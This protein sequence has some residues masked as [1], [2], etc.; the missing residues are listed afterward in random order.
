MCGIKIFCGAYQVNFGE[1]E[2]WSDGV[3]EYGFADEMKDRQVNFFP[4]TPSPQYSNAPA[5]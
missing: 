5:S 3:L 1:L 4:I 2:Y